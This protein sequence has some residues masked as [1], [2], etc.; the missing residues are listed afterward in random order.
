M[1]AL[2]RPEEFWSG[3]YSG[4]AIAILSHGG[5]WIVYLD[6]I[7]QNRMQFATAEAAVAWL[8]RKVDTLPA[9]TQRRKTGLDQRRLPPIGVG[10]E[11][12]APSAP[13]EPALAAFGK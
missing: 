5:G 6:H 8:R 11:Q 7:L 12:K 10:A 1:H 13:F 2:E 4:H 9:R 3:N